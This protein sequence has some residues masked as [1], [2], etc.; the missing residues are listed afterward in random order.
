MSIRAVCVQTDHEMDGMN[1]KHGLISLFC[2]FACPCH[3]RHNLANQTL[4]WKSTA[5]QSF[6]VGTPTTAQGMQTLLL[7]IRVWFKKLGEVAVLPL[8]VAS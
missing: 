2:L 5:Q 6:S 4:V 7:Y 3:G 8:R 1:R